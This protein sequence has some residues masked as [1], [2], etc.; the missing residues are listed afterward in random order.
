M[1]CLLTL[2]L[3]VWQTLHLNV[4]RAQ[5]TA[6]QCAMMN[7]QWIFTGV[8]APELVVFRAWRQWCSTGCWESC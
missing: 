1:S 2:L 8:F 3:C 7:V 4:P 5:E 6:T